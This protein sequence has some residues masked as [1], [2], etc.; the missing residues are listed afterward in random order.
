MFRRCRQHT[1][2]LTQA[3]ATSS[4]TTMYPTRA[5]T[6]NKHAE[7]RHYKLVHAYIHIRF[8]AQT[9]SVNRRNRRRHTNITLHTRSYRSCTRNKLVS[10]KVASIWMLCV[11]AYSPHV[12]SKAHARHNMCAHVWNATSTTALNARTCMY[13][14][15]MNAHVRV[16]AVC[17]Q[18]PF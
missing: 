18:S 10:T 16:R 17:M 13:T 9:I 1:H 12:T 11:A 14:W 15:I 8:H 6:R 4:T 7:Y 3:I 5:D 2:T